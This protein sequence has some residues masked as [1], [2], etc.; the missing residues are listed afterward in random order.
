MEVH[1][2]GLILR[3]PERKGKDKN[4][5]LNCKKTQQQL[6]WNSKTTLNN[7]LKKTINY[8]DTIIKN[9]DLKDTTFNI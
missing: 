4:Y 9:V 5:F 8:Y 2:T 7:G 6:R 3:K 1:T